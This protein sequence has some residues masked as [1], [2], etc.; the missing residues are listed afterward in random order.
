MFTSRFFRRVVIVGLT[1]GIIQ[2]SRIMQPAPD[3]I[4]AAPVFA[5]FTVDSLLDDDDINPGNGVCDSNP[6]P[7]VVVCTLRAAI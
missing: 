4:H 5:S 1:A 3:K 2:C 6:D 7:L